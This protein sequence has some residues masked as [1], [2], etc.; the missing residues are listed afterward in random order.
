M[1][2][3]IIL[4][5]LAGL[6]FAS[7][8]AQQQMSLNGEWQF[9]LAANKISADSLCNAGFYNTDYVAEG[10]NSLAVPSCWAIKGYEEPVYREFKTAP[11]SEGFYIHR[12]FVPKEYAKKRLLL[13]FGGVWAS[14][15][16]WINGEWTG[17]HDSG[18][19][20]FAL[21]VTD[22]INAGKENLI[23]V[24]VRQ[25]YPGYAADTYDDWSLGGIYR[26]VVL[27]AMP[28]K[29][30]I[31]R[32]R[33]TT[34]LDDNY[35]DAKLTVK[36]M[37]GDKIKN[38]LPGNY[39]SPGKPYQLRMALKDKQGNTV[40]QR[41]VSIKAHTSTSREHKE[42][43]EIGSPALWTAETP[44]LYTLT[45]ELIESDG[46]VAHSRTER[47]GFREI[48]TEGGVFRINGQAVKLRGV[49][50]HDEHP[51][52]GR[53]TTK[54]HWL[55]DLQLMKQANINYIRTAHYQHARGF[56]EMCD[57]IGMYVGSEVSLG[58]AGMTMYDPGFIAGVQ[59]RTV[60]T[61]ERDLNSP[62]VV[63]WSVGNEDP[64]TD[65]HLMAVKT[66]KGLDPTRPVLLPWNEADALPEDVDIIAPHYWTA[67][68]Y[69][70]L[71]AK[72]TRPIISTEYTHAY[73]EYR[74]GGLQDRWNALTKHKTGAG[75]AVWMW[76][77]QGI[78]TPTLRDEQKYGKIVKDNKYLRMSTDG[79]DGI[80]DSYRKPTRDFYELK[81]VYAPVRT[82]CEVVKMDSKAKSVSIP[83]RNDYDF[84]DLDKVEI[85]WQLYSNGRLLDSGK[86][87]IS[88]KPH[89]TA[90]LNLQLKKISRMK[91][92]EQ[93]YLWV[94]FNDN[95]GHEI[96]RN[97]VELKLKNDLESKAKTVRL[98]LK[99]NEN[100]IM[101][102]AGKTVYSFSRKTGSVAEIW[103]NGKLMASDMGATVWHKL[104]DGDH[105]I[106]NRNFKSGQGLG[107]L[108]P[109]V[110]DFDMEHAD[111]AVTVKSQVEYFVN[112][113]NRVSASFVYR[114]DNGG[115]LH[116]SY[117]IETD[118]Q[119]TYLPMVGMQMKMGKGT[120]TDSWYGKGPQDAYPNKL[121]AP[122]I[123]LWD[124]K[125]MTGTHHMKS[126]VLSNGKATMTIT[127]DA[128][129]DRD[130]MESD[131]LR[132]VHHVLGRS[133]K[134]RLNEQH[135]RVTPKGTYG[136]KFT[137]K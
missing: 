119:T 98:Q 76:A 62:S 29:R 82:D 54:E 51:D 125:N 43:I 32:V 20:S 58:G 38:T 136:G 126:L 75:A 52:V 31:E 100:K 70:S 24:R 101:V 84:T 96:G 132:I 12:F 66:V 120:V 83:I 37:V 17:R 42:V 102:E 68:Q 109:Q 131:I 103:K 65:L 115:E 117:E 39:M 89:T 28:G 79:W 91:K 111:D 63:Y 55:Q 67:A 73:G 99:E 97:G 13:H 50:R 9:R 135:Y 22:E 78:M 129:C 46:K 80:V 27:E 105:I 137:I 72:A 2:K 134:G 94:A 1:K 130:D 19:T 116:V 14:A 124:A 88:A 16:V 104:N 123:G 114:V 3:K 81:A 92:G 10:F 21:D 18:Y 127:A 26:D 59:L 11:H 61:V 113:S 23:A 36:V 45:T 48:S 57:S 44:N 133:E 30:W 74:F 47:V 107:K 25:V 128:Y 40:A 108:K 53:S 122:I 90:M 49:N 64:L 95:A 8:G 15:E 93:A 7:A 71:A 77:D 118:V 110:K 33:V 56:I 69:D 112:D 41:T 121:A 34:D 6:G 35:R 85:C 87:R 86:N 106:R 4:S 5:L 60:E